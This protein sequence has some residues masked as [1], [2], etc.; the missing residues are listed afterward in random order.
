[1]AAEDVQ[2]KAGPALDLALEKTAGLGARIDLVLAMVRIGLFFQDTPMITS[3]I[4][5]ALEYVRQSRPVLHLVTKPSSLINS[6]GDW[7]RR[8]RLKVYRA[9]HHLSI[10]EFSQAAELL[11]DSL[12]TFT[13]TE[14]M[15]YEELVALTV[16]AAAVGCTRKE[17]KAKV[18]PALSLTWT[19]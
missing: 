4:D 15:E 16:L 12:S 3:N 5:K 17:I 2:E 19:P 10:R 11:I 8:N 6:G 13:A 1:M 7:D 9:L 14:L 18:G